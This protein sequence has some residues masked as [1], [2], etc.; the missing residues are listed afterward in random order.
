MAAVF[1]CFLIFESN[2]QNQSEIN[3]DSIYNYAKTPPRFPD[4]EKA[5]VE[6]LSDNIKY[7]KA[8]KK[9]K[10]EGRVLLTFIV[11]KDG[12]LSEISVYRSVG[13]GCDEEALRVVEEMPL[14]TPARENGR[15]VRCRYTLPVLFRLE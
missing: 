4:G 11:E 3:P 7:P 1:L 9:Q 14:W 6:Y 8:A 2:A 10:I 5:L 15:A 13:G 12:S